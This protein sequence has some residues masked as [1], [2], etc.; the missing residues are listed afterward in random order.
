M[1]RIAHIPKMMKAIAMVAV[2][3]TSNVS[4]TCTKDKRQIHPKMNHQL[5]TP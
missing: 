5:R 1:A 3:T 4:D 2:V